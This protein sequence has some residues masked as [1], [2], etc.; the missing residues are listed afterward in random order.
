MV[1]SKPI[2]SVLACAESDAIVEA[3]FEHGESAY[4]CA[5]FFFLGDGVCDE[6]S[7]D[8]LFTGYAASDNSCDSGEWQIFLEVLEVAVASENHAF[9]F[10][11]YAGYPSCAGV[12]YCV[13]AFEL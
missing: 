13:D 5:C 6:A 7:G 3:L 12:D 9:G 2:S 4:E 11:V 1:G 10:A 8:A